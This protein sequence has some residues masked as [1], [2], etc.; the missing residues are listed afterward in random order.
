MFINEYRSRD[1]PTVILPAPMMISGSDLYGQ[2]RPYFRGANH[3]I[4]PEDID[5]ICH[6]RCHYDLRELTEDVH[7]HIREKNS[8][9]R[10]GH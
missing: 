8:M 4:A 6:A 10:Q 1:N 2:M 5:A 3:F 9:D 7:R